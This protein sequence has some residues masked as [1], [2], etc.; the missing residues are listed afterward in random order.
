MADEQ[1]SQDTLLGQYAGF[2]TRLMAWIIDRLIVSGILAL[3]G[4][5]ITWLL[6]TLK[7]DEWLQRTGWAALIAIILLITIPI[8]IQLLYTMGFWVLAG[9]TPGKRVM[10]IR[11]VRT[12]GSRVT[13]GNAIRREIGYWLS[14]ILFLGY[15]WILVDNRR[16]GWHDKLAGTLVVY[17]WPEGGGTPVR[18]RL[19]RFGSRKQAS[20]ADTQ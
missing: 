12:D 5:A 20:R 4:V 18:D 7:L 1:N 9:Q 10:G 14:Y 13:W 17:A 15:L 19:E 3:W 6:S 2:V 11:L 16:Q 8:V